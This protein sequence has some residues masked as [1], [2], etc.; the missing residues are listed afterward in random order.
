MKKLLLVSILFLTLTSCQDVIE[1]ELNEAPP[2]LVVEANINILENSTSINSFIKLSTT[3]PFFDN[4]IPVVEDASIQITDEDGIIYPFQHI[5]NGRYDGS[6]FPDSNMVYTLKI[7]YQ[8]EMYEG[9]TKFENTVP[10]EFVEQR[11]DGGFSGDDIELKAYFTDPVGKGNFYY[12]KGNSE[13][14]LV[15]TAF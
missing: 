15:L 9:S 3:A 14:G 8:G 2:R 1:I 6:F 13:R 4:D 7:L 5:G 11:D 12:F 10:L